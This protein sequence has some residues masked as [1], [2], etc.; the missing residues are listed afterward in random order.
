MAE[1]PI[2]TGDQIDWGG[3]GAALLAAEPGQQLGK[4]RIAEPGHE[5]LDRWHGGTITAG[6]ASQF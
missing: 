3:L 4:C 2:V 5:Q 6:L 1:G